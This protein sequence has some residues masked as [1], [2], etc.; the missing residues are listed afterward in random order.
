MVFG[1]GHNRDRDETDTNHA[2]YTGVYLGWFFYDPNVGSANHRARARQSRTW[3]AT[4]K[5][6]IR[7]TRK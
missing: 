6:V 2:D 1:R 5:K 7:R 3:T 4:C